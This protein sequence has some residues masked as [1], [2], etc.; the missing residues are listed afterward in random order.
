VSAR[1]HAYQRGVVLAVPVFE[2]RLQV[3]PSGKR[4]PCQCSSL[5][6]TGDQEETDS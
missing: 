4:L 2:Q 5:A 3:N 6:V 1:V